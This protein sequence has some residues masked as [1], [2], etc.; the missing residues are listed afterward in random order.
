MNIMKIILKIMHTMLFR[1]A[2][3]S[4]TYPCPSVRPFS[5]SVFSEKVFSVSVF[6]KVF[7]SERIFLECVFSESVFSESVLSESVCSESVFQVC[8]YFGSKLYWPKGYPVQTFSNW[9]YPT[10][11]ASSELLRACFFFGHRQQLVAPIIMWHIQM[12]LLIAN[13]DDGSNTLWKRNLFGIQKE[14]V[15]K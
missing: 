7:F 14:S 12:S 3:S 15:L 2:S 6:S 13:I 8:K 9:V 4:S 11:C 1:C 10:A 5:E